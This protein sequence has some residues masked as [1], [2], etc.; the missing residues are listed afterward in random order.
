VLALALF[1][2]IVVAAHE[3]FDVMDLRIVLYYG[4]FLF[5]LYSGGHD[6]FKKIS[7]TQLVIAAL[8]FTVFIMVRDDY[9]FA[10]DPFSSLTSFL[11]TNVLMLLF[12]S[13]TYKSSL[14]FSDRIKLKRLVEIVSYSSFCMF[15]F[16][17]V[18]KFL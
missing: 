8:L 14:F 13:F 12:I 15:L 1:P 16:G 7:W 4:I 11:I 5:G 2:L 10:V 18:L 3:M 17:N 6:V 9:T